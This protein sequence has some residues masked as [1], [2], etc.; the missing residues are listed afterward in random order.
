ML[1][2]RVGGEGG[3]EGVVGG[4]QAVPLKQLAPE[5]RNHYLYSELCGFD[6]KSYLYSSVAAV[7]A[8]GAQTHFFHSRVAAEQSGQAKLMH[9]LLKPWAQP[10][11]Q[12]G[13]KR[14]PHKYRINC[15]VLGCSLSTRT[16]RASHRNFF[17]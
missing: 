3:M 13:R 11:R 12:G 6:S 10:G 17:F 1:S 7:R 14:H 9:S 8:E 15:E 5:L 4:G 2:E 16:E